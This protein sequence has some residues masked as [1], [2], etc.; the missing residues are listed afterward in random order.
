MGACARLVRIAPWQ[1]A[2]PI[3]AVLFASLLLKEAFTLRVLLA[4][5]IIVTGIIVAHRA[6]TA[7]ADQLAEA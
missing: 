1:F 3:L 2:Q 6:A 7:L 5:I 4:A